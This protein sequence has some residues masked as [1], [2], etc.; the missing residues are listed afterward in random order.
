MPVLVGATGS[1]PGVYSIGMGVPVEQINPHWEKARNNP[2]APV[3]VDDAPCQE[4]I[5][6][7]SALDELGKVEFEL[8]ENEDGLTE[9][10][11]SENF[12]GILV[13]PIMKMIGKTT[14]NNFINMNNALKER[15]END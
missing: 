5:I 10:I 2:I 6:E 14:E 8:Q 1:S 7:G 13:W 12:A 3:I 9:F 4:V 11:H 15:P